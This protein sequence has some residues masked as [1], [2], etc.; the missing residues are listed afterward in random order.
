MSI[1]KVKK[2][3]TDL[4]ENFDKSFRDMILSQKFIVKTTKMP[5]L[6]RVDIVSIEKDVIVIEHPRN[7]NIIY[8]ISDSWENIEVFMEHVAT[9]YNEHA[10]HYREVF[11]EEV[12]R[13]KKWIAWLETG[14]ESE[15]FEWNEK[16]KLFIQNRMLSIK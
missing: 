10:D 6:V 16:R 15:T 4:I 5:C 3:F 7:A 8:I 11:K 13:Y 9:K 14:W 1:E 2:D 12:D